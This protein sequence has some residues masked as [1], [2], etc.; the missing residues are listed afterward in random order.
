MIGI[1]A[2]APLDMSGGPFAPGWKGRSAHI[3][4][5]ATVTPLVDMLSGKTTCATVTMMSGVLLWGCQ[6]L[7]HFT[8]TDFCYEL[9]EAAFAWQHDWRYVDV[10]AEPYFSPPDDPPEETA[11]YSLDEFVRD[12]IEDRDKWTSFYQPIM[13]LFHMCNMVNFILPKAH[14]PAFEGW[15]SGMAA[16]L[17]QIA[18]SPD[19]EVPDFDDFESEAAYDAYCAPKRGTA[20]PPQVLDLDA[21]LAGL[22]LQAAAD[23]F[24]RGLD[25]KK[26][27]FLLAPEKLIEM[28]FEGTPYGRAP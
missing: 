5:V 16:R 8:E 2:L 20:L 23:T 7:K 28:G 6:R 14:R 10:T 26:N 27:R 24:L 1:T 25:H 19:M 11:L 9:A 3:G 4:P 12:S 21:D 13:P 18:T 17:D 15:L 22:D